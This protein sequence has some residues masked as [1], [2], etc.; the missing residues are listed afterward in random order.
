MFC[1]RAL[2]S[3]SIT[4]I[5]TQALNV[6]GDICVEF[7]YNMYGFHVGTLEL[8]TRDAFNTDT[9]QWTQAKQQGNRW[10]QQR[11]TVSNFRPGSQVRWSVYS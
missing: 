9:V 6:D 10:I 5:T 11:S 3:L 1:I 4:S 2:F 7:A 8:F